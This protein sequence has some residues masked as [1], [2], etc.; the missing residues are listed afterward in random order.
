MAEHKGKKKGGKVTRLM[1][2]LIVFS[3]MFIALIF[4]V[5]WLQ[6]VRDRKSVV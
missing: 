5:G 6:T 3:V 4:R 2:V 1:T